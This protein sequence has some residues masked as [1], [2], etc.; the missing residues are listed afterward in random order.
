MFAYEIKAADCSGLPSMLSRLVHEAGVSAVALT[1]MYSGPPPNEVVLDAALH[2][3]V[4][5]PPG[6]TDRLELRGFDYGHVQPWIETAKEIHKQI[7]NCRNNHPG[8]GEDVDDI[9]QVRPAQRG[10]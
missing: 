6:R 10:R 3:L 8:T 7:T 2:T 9:E 4:F 1:G 5:Y